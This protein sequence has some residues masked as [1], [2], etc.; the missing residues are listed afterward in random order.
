MAEL[1]KNLTHLFCTSMRLPWKALH[2][3]NFLTQT[4][5]AGESTG[6][7]SRIMQVAMDQ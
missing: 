1:L 5:T 4:W 2:H 3:R 6:R 7:V